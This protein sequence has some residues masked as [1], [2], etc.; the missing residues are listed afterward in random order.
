VDNEKT[1]N[2][3]FLSIHKMKETENT[4]TL[5]AMVSE[6]QYALYDG[7]RYQSTS[8]SRIPTRLTYIKASDGSW[9]LQEVT[10]SGDG[11]EYY[12]SILAFCN[13]DAV[14][15][16]TLANDFSADTDQCFFRYLE[17]NGYPIPAEIPY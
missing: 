17:H 12:P 16:K 9:C 8:G 10:E 6:S 15:A 13:N 2:I 7:N 3:V 4:L 1:V 11:T 14:L 5:W